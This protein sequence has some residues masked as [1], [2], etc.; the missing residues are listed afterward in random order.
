MP[1][2]DTKRINALVK[3]FE[4]PPYKHYKNWT[5]EYEYPGVFVYYLK[6]PDM[7][8]YFTPDYT[9]ANEI[10]MQINFGDDPIDGGTAPFYSYKAEDLFAIVKQWLDFIVDNIKQKDVLDWHPDRVPWTRREDR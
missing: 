2:A 7:R 5:F 6:S 9:N 4:K 8:L 3:A 1:K 10:D